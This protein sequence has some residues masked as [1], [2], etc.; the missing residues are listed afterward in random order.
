MRIPSDVRSARQIGCNVVSTTSYTWHCYATE[1]RSSKEDG[2][3][4]CYQTM[5]ITGKIVVNRK[6]HWKPKQSQK[7]FIDPI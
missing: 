2:H 6:T 4:Q 3:Y 7:E 5:V 1:Y